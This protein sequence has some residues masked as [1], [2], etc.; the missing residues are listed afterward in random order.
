MNLEQM[1]DAE[2]VRLGVPASDTFYTLETLT[3]LTNE[4][5]QA[6]STE[7]DWPWLDGTVSFSTVSGT[8]TYTPPADWARTRGLCIDGFD[9]MEYRSLIELREWPTTDSD[10]PRYYHINE[11]AIT[12]RP[13]PGSVNTVIHDYVKTEATLVTPADVPFMPAQFH[14]SVVAYAV[15]LAFLRQGDVQRA[16]A[17]LGDYQGWL[18]RMVDN[19]RRQA[20]GVRVRVRPG[21]G[22]A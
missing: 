11:E 21:G 22:F 20:G 18:K 16:T 9:A 5:L 8:A 14:Y 2:R 1:C 15:H 19:R 7:F 3:D 4:A 17:A 6:I 12:L 13:V 10:V